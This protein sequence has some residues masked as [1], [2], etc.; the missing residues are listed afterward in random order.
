[1]K[2]ELKSIKYA[3]FSSEETNCYSATLYINGKKIGTVGNDGHGGPDRFHGDHAAFAEADAWCK[4]NLPRWQMN[5]ESFETDLEMRCGQLVDEWLVARD[6]KTALRTKVLMRNPVDGLIYQVKHRGRV[7]AT[8]K[9]IEERHP[10]A[11]I[12][13]TLPFEEALTL[14]RAAASS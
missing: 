7:Q 9:T 10:G 6:L 14:Y 11:T 13:N 3:A 5:D 8:A 2:I 12:L 1:M 4:A